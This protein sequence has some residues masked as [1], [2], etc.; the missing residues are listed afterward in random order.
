MG[1]DLDDGQAIGRLRLRL[2]SIDRSVIAALVAREDAQW[3]LFDLKQ[4]LALPLS[5]PS[6]ESLVRER[7]R[8]WALEAGGDPDLAGRVVM[9]A[10]RSGRRRFLS[11]RVPRRIR[12]V[13]AFEA[14]NGLPAPA[15]HSRARVAVAAH[16]GK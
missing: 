16:A 6:Q 7:A 3:E 11:S 10:L 9:A 15:T 13:P 5:E 14:L 2:E 4:L 1:R 8:R 12:R